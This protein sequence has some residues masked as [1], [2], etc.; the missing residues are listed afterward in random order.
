MQ[1]KNE[2]IILFF[3]HGSH[4]LAHFSMLI[5]PTFALWIQNEIS[6][7]LAQTLNLGFW[8]YLFF[9]LFALPVG[10]LNDR[11]KQSSRWFLIVFLIGT[12]LG[13]LWI[14]TAKMLYTCEFLCYF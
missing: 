8:M 13:Y 7:S 1:S 12:S 14:A 9:G 11:W 10:Y 3:C 4:Y 6:L 5:F 2:S